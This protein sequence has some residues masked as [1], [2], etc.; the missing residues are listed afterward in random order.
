M[1]KYSIFCKIDGTCWDIVIEANYF[2][3]SQSG[4]YEFRN[5]ITKQEWYFP[6]YRTVIKRV[7]DIEK[8]NLTS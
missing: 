8:D 5:T 3:Y 7:D 6:V 2:T 4:V 1:K